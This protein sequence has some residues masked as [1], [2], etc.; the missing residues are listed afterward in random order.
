VLTF[1]CFGLGG[2]YVLTAASVA[3]L[4]FSLFGLWRTAK[5]EKEKE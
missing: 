4:L 2:A 3:A 1:L 5:R